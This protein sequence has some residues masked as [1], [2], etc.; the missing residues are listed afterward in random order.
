MSCGTG[1]LVK[2]TKWAITL[3]ACSCRCWSCP[4]CASR[5]QWRCEQ[6]I[7]AGEPNIFIT[8]GCQ[9]DRYDSPE[10]ARAD[11]GRAMPKLA[12]RIRRQ[13]PDFDFQYATY[14]EAF[15]SGWPHFHIACRSHYIPQ[16]WLAQ[17]LKE[18]LG[19]PV[20][21]IEHAGTPKQIAKYLCKYLVKAP[22]QFGKSKRYF[23][24]QGYLPAPV[25]DESRKRTPMVV[26]WYR[27]TLQQVVAQITTADV[28]PIYD[29]PDR[30]LLVRLPDP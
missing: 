5:R 10:E 8:F 6:E 27:D 15:K 19:A 18:L 28:I 26:K 25:F 4:E 1:T 14:C 16:K 21:W 11:M 24:S 20:C 29:G 22:H 23:Y 30:V 3:T 2:S 13:W 17:Q 9:P 12:K 7:I